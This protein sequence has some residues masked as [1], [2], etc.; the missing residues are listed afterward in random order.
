VTEGTWSSAA[1]GSSVLRVEAAERLES[2]VDV[3]VGMVVLAL[4]ESEPADDAQTR[5]VRP[6]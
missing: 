5:A 4:V 3:V 6:A 2:W 1:V